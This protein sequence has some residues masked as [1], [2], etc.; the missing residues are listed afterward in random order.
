MSF[1]DKLPAPSSVPIQ[2]IRSLWAPR[3]LTYLW[4]QSITSVLPIVYRPLLDRVWHKQTNNDGKFL[5]TMNSLKFEYASHKHLEGGFSRGVKQEWVECEQQRVCCVVWIWFPP[6]WK[7]LKH[8]NTFCW[9]KWWWVPQMSTTRDF[10]NLLPVDLLSCS[11][12]PRTPLLSSVV[13][14][15]H[16]SWANRPGKSTEHAGGKGK[17]RHLTSRNGFAGCPST[18]KSPEVTASEC[19]DLSAFTLSCLREN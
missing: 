17:G 11:T 18:G 2:P 10:W 19:G 1:S 5:P 9:K 16:S 14:R 6:L 4:N 13:L 15:N 8:A 3:W 7:D 12:L